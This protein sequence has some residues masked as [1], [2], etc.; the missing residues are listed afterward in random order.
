MFLDTKDTKVEKSQSLLLSSTQTGWEDRHGMDNSLESNVMRERM[1][2]GKVLRQQEGRSQ[3]GHHY[4]LPYSVSFQDHFMHSDRTRKYVTSK[5]AKNSKFQLQHANGLSLYEGSLQV[6]GQ[7]LGCKHEA[8]D[9]KSLVK[10]GS[11]RLRSRTKILEVTQS[12]KMQMFWPRSEWRDSSIT[13]TFTEIPER[14]R[15]NNHTP[16]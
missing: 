14:S 3:K 2:E 10:N 1:R 15:R 13:Q 9:S 4:C 7:N 5:Y 8:R 11:Y 16:E 6:F 12:Q